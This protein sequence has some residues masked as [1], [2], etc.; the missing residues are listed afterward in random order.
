MAPGALFSG[1][2]P[3]GFLSSEVRTRENCSRE[4]TAFSRFRRKKGGGAETTL[5]TI[6]RRQFSVVYFDWFLEAL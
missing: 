2:T 6:P 3:S 5:M 4:A 1:L